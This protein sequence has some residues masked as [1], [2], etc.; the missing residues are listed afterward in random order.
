[1]RGD[2]ESHKAKLSELFIIKER[3]VLGADGLHEI[4][5]L[6]RVITYH[7]AKPRCPETSTCEAD[8]RNADLLIASYGLTPS[9]KTKATPWDKAAFLARHPLARSFL[10][11][12]RRVAFGSNCLRCVNLT[13]T[14]RPRRPL[15]LW[16]RRLPTPSSFAVLGWPSSRAVAIIWARMAWKGLGADRLELGRL[17]GD[18]QELIGNLPH[19][20]KKSCLRSQLNTD[21][22]KRRS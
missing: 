6:N 9:S 20:G 12:K 1:M 21:D 5:I 22:L 17:P 15:V 18:S 7:P 4:R 2:L 14:L 8:Q 10:D 19:A 13:S 16:R 11:E 3:G